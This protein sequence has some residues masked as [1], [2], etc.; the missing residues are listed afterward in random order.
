M[1]YIWLRY[2]RC[3]TMSD[4]S[5]SK[6]NR[7]SSFKDTPKVKFIIPSNK[8]AC[9]EWVVLNVIIPLRFWSKPF[10]GASPLKHIWLL[11]FLS[12]YFYRYTIYLEN[13]LPF[14]RGLGTTNLTV[15]PFY[16]NYSTHFINFCAN[17]ILFGVFE[18]AQKPLEC[19]SNFEM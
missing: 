3:H 6:H 5:D 10:S 1:F 8:V 14:L 7:K 19:I 2:K 17:R 16:R 15:S 13:V 12:N 9:P 11:F 18:R 4:I